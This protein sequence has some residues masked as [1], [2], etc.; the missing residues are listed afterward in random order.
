MQRIENKGRERGEGQERGMDRMEVGRE[1]REQRKGGP[2]GQCEGDEARRRR[3]NKTGREGGGRG[4]AG[5]A[6]T[7]SLSHT[8][9]HSLSLPFLSLLLL[10]KGEMQA[11]GT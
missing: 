2:E 9:T 6:L 4:D 1:Q 11:W 8:H 3:A 10:A 7:L 5:M